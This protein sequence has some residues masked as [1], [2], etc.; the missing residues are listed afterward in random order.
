MNQDN[1]ARANTTVYDFAGSCIAS[2]PQGGFLQGRQGQRPPWGAGRWPRA[3]QSGERSEE[4]T[5]VRQFHSAHY[6]QP[7]LGAIRRAQGSLSP[8][9][10]QG[11]VNLPPGRSCVVAAGVSVM[12]QFVTTVPVRDNPRLCDK[13][14]VF[15]HEIGFG[16]D[17]NEGKAPI[18]QFFK[19]RTQTGREPCC[20]PLN[21]RTREFAFGAKR[22]QNIARGTE[23]HAERKKRAHSRKSI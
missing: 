22:A 4:S 19:E 5:P 15:T 1:C 20:T 17:R 14:T 13:S 23:Q 12:C 8:C 10:W 16:C 18:Y 3:G 2:A 11:A 6:R 7:P 9:R 21:A